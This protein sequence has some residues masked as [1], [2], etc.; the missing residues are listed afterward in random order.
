MCVCV[1]VCVCVRAV[2]LDILVQ[3]VTA[4]LSFVFVD[5]VPKI[6][7]NHNGETAFT[8]LTVALDVRGSRVV[9]PG[10]SEWSLAEEHDMLYCLQL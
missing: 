10:H 6:K 2:F 1:C 3:K 4:L 8:H 7:A 9:R 5:S